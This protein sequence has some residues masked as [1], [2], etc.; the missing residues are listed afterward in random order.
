MK[1]EEMA[2]LGKDREGVSLS[3]SLSFWTPFSV[4]SLH[5]HSVLGE[6]LLSSRE[7][8]YSSTSVLQNCNEVLKSSKSLKKNQIQRM[9]Q[10]Q[11]E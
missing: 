11:I 10:L 6:L 8:L 5:L 2:S 7:A 3:P 1:K 4:S 9:T